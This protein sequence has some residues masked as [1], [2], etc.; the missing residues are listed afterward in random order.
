MIEGS[1]TYD[2]LPDVDQEAYVV[3]AKKTIA[4]VLKQ[5]GIVEFRAQRSMM[6][7]PQI[8]TITVWR[9][10]A[11]WG[12]FAEGPWNAAEAELRRFATNIKTELWGPSALVPE[13]LRPGK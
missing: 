3:W 1:Q 6:G 2:L 11:D 10:A 9:S 12:N 7:T 5:P 8:R 13:P 4:M